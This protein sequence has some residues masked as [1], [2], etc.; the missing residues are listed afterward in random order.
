MDK[1]ALYTRLP[2]P[3]QHAVVSL[4]GSRIQLSRFGRPFRKYLAEYKGRTY[5]SG[6]A[7][8]TFR[9]QRLTEFIAHAVQSTEHYRGLFKELGAEPGDFRSLGDLKRLPILTKRQ[10]QEAPDRFT[11]APSPQVKIIVAHTSGTTGAGLRFPITLDAHAEQWAVWWRYRNWHGI[12]PDIPCLY[13]GGRSVV[14]QAQRVPPFWRY[15]LPGRQILF[16]GYHVNRENAVAYLHEMKRSGHVWIHGYPS[17]V[18]L[19]AAY[20]LEFGEKLPMRWVTLG[21]E[22][23]LPQQAA[24]IEAAFGV[25]PI[26][27]YGLAEGVANVS[28]CPK[29][30]FHVDED[31]AAVEFL[32]N[33]AG[34]CN[35]IG[36]N[37][38]NRAFP[39]IR[40]DTGDVAELSG[41]A[42]DCGRPGRI[43][44]DIDGRKEDYVVGKSGVRIG[45]MDHIFKDMVNIV[46]SQIRQD[47][48][49]HMTLA[50]VKGPKYAERDEQ[51]LRE[52]IDRRVGNDVAFD[53]EYVKHIDRTGSGKLRFVVS[54]HKDT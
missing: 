48:P 9:A 39:L 46:E 13:F 52:E 40:Y 22:N 28:M 5:S 3:F 24:V 31:Y 44:D 15:N 26:T 30:R 36:T 35:V 41:A 34:G 16:S 19:I 12:A 21:A 50:I 27:H 54:T 14:P 7:I 11:A 17:I 49:G 47:R 8:R 43:V 42:C 29:G 23:V 25:R 37:L 38:S 10:V 2:I 53:V 18:A 51:R 45:R 20:A 4:E 1:E 32:P 6:D 33:E